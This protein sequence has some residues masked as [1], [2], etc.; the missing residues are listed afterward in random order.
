[1]YHYIDSVIFGFRAVSIL[2]FW[3][4]RY[5]IISEVS[6]LTTSTFPVTVV[7][8]GSSVIMTVMATLVSRAP[9]LTDIQILPLVSLHSAVVVESIAG[10][11]VSIVT[12][13]VHQQHVQKMN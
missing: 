12:I 3:V 5:F 1:M 9:I 2:S 7:C 6:L 8:M 4:L 11:Q 10:M 13:D